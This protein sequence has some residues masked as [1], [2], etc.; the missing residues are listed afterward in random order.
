M[1][2]LFL[3]RLAAAVLTIGAMV[4]CQSSD[5]TSPNIEGSAEATGLAG[6]TRF[7]AGGGVFTMSNAATGNE[8]L[9]YR[10][11]RNG[12]VVELAAVPT[13]GMGTGA[14]LGNQSGLIVSPDEDWMIAVNAG[15]NDISVMKVLGLSLTVTDVEPAGGA[16]PISVTMH[17]NLVYV[18]NAGDP[19]NVPG[20]IQ[21]FELS[22]D[23]DLT[24]IAGSAQALSAADV[25]PAQ[26]AFSAD[27]GVL[28]VTEKGTNNIVT[29]SVGS[30][31]KASA[32]NVQAS[33]G[34]TPF[35]FAVTATNHVLVSEAFGG[36]AGESAVSSYALV[37]SNLSTVEASLPTTQTAAC[38]VAVTPDGA[39]AYTANTGSSTV[40]GLSVGPG[41]EIALLDADGVTGET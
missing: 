6:G 41:G 13:G 9:R 1:S 32:P 2:K 7:Q 14:G 20:N 21:G 17:D 30:D 15:S 28:I 24:P 34:Q 12:S 39:Y 29:Y 35:G 18:L 37:G 33:N 10:R 8:I 19:G 11:N 25:G 36:A 26:I 22:P 38:W 3:G 31:G 23:G 5:P 4:G 16:T 40:T 27:G